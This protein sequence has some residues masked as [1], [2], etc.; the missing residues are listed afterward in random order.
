MLTASLHTGVSELASLTPV[1]KDESISSL[2]VLLGQQ[3]DLR[4][5]QAH[6]RNG[7]GLPSFQ[8]P[9]YELTY[10][11]ANSMMPVGSRR[12]FCTFFDVA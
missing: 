6:P 3:V 10:T 4:Q 9:V 11:L 8:P 2:A 7:S 1:C 12:K 5:S